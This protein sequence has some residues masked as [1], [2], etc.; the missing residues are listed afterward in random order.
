MFYNGLE[1]I[2]ME[3]ANKRTG[4]VIKRAVNSLQKVLAFMVQIREGEV[5]RARKKTVS[6][7]YPGLGTPGV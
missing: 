7:A 2:N 4:V 6:A 1:S 3:H 5:E